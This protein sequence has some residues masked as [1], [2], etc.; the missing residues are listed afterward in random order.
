M[1]LP[2]S[3]TSNCARILRRVWDAD[4][5]LSPHGI[6]S[7]SRAHAAAPFVFDDRSVAYEPGE[8]KSKIKGGNSNWRGP[9]WFPT[10]IM[11]IE[12]L[13]TLGESLGPT[14][15]PWQAV[16][17]LSEADGKLPPTLVDLAHD[18]AER[19]MSLFRRDG[20]GRRPI[21]GSCPRFQ[22]DPHWRDLLLFYEYFHGDTGQGL[23]PRTRPAGLR[24]SRRCS[25]NGG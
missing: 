15:S 13:R 24:W 22:N 16:A 25:T 11:L 20:S 5:F 2:S 19:L 7:L 1:S 17:G 6:R 12:A 18:L 14:Y 9:V 10:C 21:H 4:E 23:A 8:A 3:T